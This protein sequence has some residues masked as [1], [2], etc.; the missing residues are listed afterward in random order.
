MRDV[1]LAALAALVGLGIAAASAAS[2]S[3]G[4]NQ[5]AEFLERLSGEWTVVSKA[6]PGPGMEPVRLESRAEARLLG[7][8]WLVEESR[9]TAAMGGDFTSI[10]TLGYDPARERFVGTFISSMQRHLW[11]YTG[12]L[13]TS[14]DVLVLETEGPILGNPQKTTR[15]REYIENKDA[16][17][18]VIR[19]MIL[20]PDGEWFEFS[21]AEYQRTD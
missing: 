6:V 4:A 15:Y 17:R 2:P 14:G 11:S 21:H 20:G 10:F 1:K 3:D 5:P 19:S 16:D 9:G 12:S 13:E 8:K 18:K 7:G